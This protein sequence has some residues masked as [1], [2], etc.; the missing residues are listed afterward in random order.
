[1]IEH[2]RALILGQKFP[3]CVKEGMKISGA[4]IA[5]GKRSTSSISGVKPVYIHINL[6]TILHGL[7]NMFPIC[8]ICSLSFNSNK[9]QCKCENQYAWSSKQCSKHGIC[10]PNQNDTCRCITS[11]QLTGHSAGH[12]LVKKSLSLFKIMLTT[13]I[14]ISPMEGFFFTSWLSS[15]LPKFA[16]PLKS[17]KYT[18][19]IKINA[20]RDSV[21]ERLRA[22]ILDRNSPCASKKAWKFPVQLSLQV[23]EVYKQ[24][25]AILSTLF[26]KNILC[27]FLWYLKNLFNFSVSL[28]CEQNPVQVWE[29][30]RLVSK[31]ML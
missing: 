20:S 26:W 15:S 21:I 12:H 23:R 16:D 9:T 22:L 19:D 28:K 7:S 31:T 14:M 1:M 4:T 10:G 11:L 5:T 8:W 6:K 30:I 24:S 27:V 2:L 3:V 13:G 25:N 18:F 29:S 17:F